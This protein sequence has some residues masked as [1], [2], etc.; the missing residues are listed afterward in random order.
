MVVRNKCPSIILN[1]L[2][3][4]QAIE[5]TNKRLRQIASCAS[6]LGFL[7]EKVVIDQKLP[8]VRN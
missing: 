5:V 4:S 8:K 3:K 6:L 7:G 2:P 1:K